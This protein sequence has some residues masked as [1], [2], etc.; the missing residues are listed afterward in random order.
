[1]K[2]ATA[3]RSIGSQRD[4]IGTIE[5]PYNLLENVNY[6]SEMKNNKKDLLSE[7]LELNS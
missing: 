1:M 4:I 6:P 3:E 5:P 2:T 7:S